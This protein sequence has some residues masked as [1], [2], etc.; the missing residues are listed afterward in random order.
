[1][2]RVGIAKED[3]NEAVFCHIKTV[4]LTNHVS[5]KTLDSGETADQFND[6]MASEQ[7]WHHD[8][9]WSSLEE[10]PPWRVA[11]VEPSAA[12]SEMLPGVQDIVFSYH[13]ALLDG[14]SG[15][16]FHENLLKELNSQLQQDA[17]SGETACS[18][19]QFPNAPRLP[20]AQDQI[21]A[22]KNST[23][24]L[25]KTLWNELG[26]TKLRAKKILPWPKKP[27]DFS[28]PY[29]TR[30]KG[31]DIQPDVV[32]KLVKAC[33]EHNTSITGLLQALALASFARRLPASEASCFA[34][35][36]PISLRPFLG[37][38]AD[39]ELRDLLRVLVTSYEHEFPS[40]VVSELRESARRAALD[41]AIWKVAQEVK[42]ELSNR[43]ATMPKDDINGLMKYNSDWFGFFEKRDGQ[44]RKCSWEVSNIGVFK[45][46]PGAAPAF[47]VSRVYFTNGAMVTGSPVGLG[48]ASVPGGV[49]TIAMSWQ[50]TVVTDEFVDNLASD[51]AS[52]ADRFGETGRF[53]E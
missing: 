34:A 23:S 4:E 42:T 49:L 21:I 53:A 29:V 41:E 28:I 44:P 52:F 18:T 5:F 25:V 48:V 47:A 19:L 38:N 11:I 27:I 43:V 14:T 7:G 32:S 40:S 35:A 30:S 6:Q 1:M 36:T 3:T 31:I 2:L 45:D 51:L 33:R 9:M 24:Y 12:A 20:E 50:Q 26:P 39:D 16:M 13:H 17:H 37:P 10:I 15:R 22:F 46:S 8:Q